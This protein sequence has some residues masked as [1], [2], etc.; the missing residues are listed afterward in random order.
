MMVNK[1]YST[2]VLAYLQKR[3]RKF[4]KHTITFMIYQSPCNNLSM[5]IAKTTMMTG[6]VSLKKSYKLLD[7]STFTRINYGTH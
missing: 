5:I 2:Q 6:E 7:G 3:R 4:M 1:A